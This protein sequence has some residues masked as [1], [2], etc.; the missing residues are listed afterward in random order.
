MAFRLFDLFRF[1]NTYDKNKRAT[2]P[3]SLSD[4]QVIAESEQSY[5]EQELETVAKPLP[6][7][8]VDVV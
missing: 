5:T 2:D 6:E 7:A 8:T 3:V 4:S 1:D